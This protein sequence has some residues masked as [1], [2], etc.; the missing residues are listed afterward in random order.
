M[1]VGQHVPDR[2]GELASDREGGELAAALASVSGTVALDDG[3]VERVAAGG[4]GCFDERPAEVV[5]AV[6]AQRAAAIAV[7]GLLDLR[8]QPGVPDQLGG[9][10][11]AGDVTDLGGDR[12]GEDPGDAGAGDQP[13]HVAVVGAEAAQLALAG[14]D[15]LVERVDQGEAGRRR[16]APG[17]R[18]GQPLEQPPAADA[19][20]VAARGGD[21]MGDQDRV[22]AVLE[23]GPMPDQVEA[24]AGAL[25]LPP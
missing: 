24:E 20:Q 16:R 9:G 19:E 11:E 18:Q 10:G 13:W 4:V 7:A 6:L 3:L 12:E 14:V 22:D 21:A 15:L 17:L 2:L 8:G 1:I 25:A 23:R 5:G